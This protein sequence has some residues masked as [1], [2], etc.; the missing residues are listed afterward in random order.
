[1]HPELPGERSASAGEAPRGRAEAGGKPEET[2]SLVLPANN[3]TNN[4]SGQLLPAA[5]RAWHGIPRPLSQHPKSK[6]LQNPH[7]AGT[8]C[9]LR[10]IKGA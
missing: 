4:T 5:L 7:Y 3:T 6:T 1:M 2:V 8:K 9:A 10:E